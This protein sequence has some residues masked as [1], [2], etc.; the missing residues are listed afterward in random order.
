M[1]QLFSLKGQV[2]FITGAGSDNGIGFASAK[3]LAEMGA[4]IAITATSERIHQRAEELEG[5]SP[6]VQS[7]ICDLTDRPATRAMIKAI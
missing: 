1:H 5:I 2:A 4:E 6:K 7:Y 3:L